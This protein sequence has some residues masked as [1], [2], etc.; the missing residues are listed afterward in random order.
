VPSERSGPLTDIRVLDAG[1]MIACPYAA[2]LL[3][4]LGAD[5]I[6]IESPTGDDM[7]HLGQKR[8]GESGSYVGI[9]RNKR[10]IVLDLRQPPGREALARLVETADVLITN[11]REP[12]LS[13]LGL[14][15]EQA[16]EHRGDIVWAGVST[17]GSD[18]P[19]AGR[20]GVDALAQALCGI[21]MLNGPPDQ[22][23]TR[24]NVPIAD[25]MSS[26]LIANGVQ[27]ALHER[28]RTGRGQKVEVALID[29]L[30]HALANSLGNYFISGWVMPRTGN[31]SPYFA[32]SGIYTCADGGS[33][34]ITCPTEKF[35]RN[36]CQALDTGWLEDPRFQSPDARLANEDALDA[37]L[38]GICASMPRHHLVDR[39][40]AGDVMV[41]P[42][43]TLNELVNDPQIMHNEM[44]LETEHP[45]LGSARV[46]GLPIRLVMTP[47]AVHRAPPLLGEHSLEVLADLGYT[48]KE[49]DALIEK[50]VTVQ[51]NIR[52]LA[53]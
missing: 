11:T 49:L 10:G 14:A 32:P 36:L 33:V 25:V 1:T 42:V 13:Q 20:P 30:V 5:V 43:N 53:P 16:R 17:F 47:G 40:V 6:K 15:Y 31:R 24:L 50:S 51:A 19:Y 34:F 37:E 46:T 4:D 41:S 18:G 23:P 52:N 3:G 7:R 29:A 48:A 21:P 2:T 39:L 12:A 45:A 22:P 28:T 26:L 8:E 38:A 44:I 9:N 35:F 27:A